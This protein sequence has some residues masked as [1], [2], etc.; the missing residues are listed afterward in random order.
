MKEPTMSAKDRPA[1]S[2]IT[3]E[4]SDSLSLGRIEIGDEV[5]AE[6]AARAA[7]KVDGVLV[8]ASSFRLSEILSGKES[9][10]KGVSV[11]TDDTTGH[12][13]VDVDV[14][15]TY[16]TVIYDAAHKLQMLIK[17]EVEALT[18]SLVVDKVNVRIKRVVVR[19]DEESEPVD[20]DRAFPEERR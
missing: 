2:P 18:G 5:I 7:M 1:H 8:V 19:E 9:S 3:P 11:R 20:P 10:R 6:I 13:E 17:D 15:V 4:Q 12:V 14:N 16:G